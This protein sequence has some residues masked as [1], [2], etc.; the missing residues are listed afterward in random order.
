MKCSKQQY[1]E[2]LKNIL[3]SLI[4]EKTKFYRIPVGDKNYYGQT[5]QTLAKRKSQHKNDFK[6]GKMRK[7]YI[8]MRECGMTADD[9]ELILVEE[10]PCETKYEAHARERYWIEKYGTLNAQVPNR[11]FKEYYETNKETISE[12]KLQYRQANVDK[13]KEQK[14]LSYQKNKNTISEKGLEYRKAN[15][16]KLNEKSKKYYQ[17]NKDT[18]LEKAHEYYQANKSNIAEKKR[19]YH[20]ENKDVICEKKRL[21]NQANKSKIAEKQREYYQRNKDTLLKKSR[22]R[23]EAKC[24]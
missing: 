6:K 21:Y 13:I 4:I 1:K 20:Q 19:E 23:Y 3:K 24:S 10:F 15:R 7:V 18:V 2:E 12:K 5:V 16:K 9:I 22:K 11:T 17:L 8:A 14:I